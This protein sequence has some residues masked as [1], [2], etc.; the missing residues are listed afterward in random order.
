MSK[1]LLAMLRG[2][3]RS[4]RAFRSRVGLLQNLSAQPLEPKAMLSGVTV[5]T[6]PQVDS[7]GMPTGKHFVFVEG[8]SADEVITARDNGA[9]VEIDCDGVVTD[10]GIAAADV[11]TLRI[12]G[13]EGD[14]TIAID[15]GLVVERTQLYGN[16][17]DDTLVG[18]V[19]VD[20]MRGGAGADVY[21]GGDGDDRMNAGSMD[22]TPIVGGS[23]YDRLTYVPD[24]GAGGLSITSADLEYV[25]G[26]G[27]P[28]TIDLSAQTANVNVQGRGG[29]D[30]LMGG[31]AH[32]TLR[33]GD[34]DDVLMAGDGNDNLLGQAG[35]DMLDG[36]AGSDRAAYNDSDA[37]VSVNLSTLTMSGGHAT[38]DAMAGIEHLA[39]SAHD[40]VLIGDAMDNVIAGLLGDDFLMGQGGGDRHY[41]SGGND[42]VSYETSPGGVRADLA[43]NGFQD[44]DAH[45]DRAFAIENLIGSEFDDSLVGNVNANLLVGLG[46]IDD[47]DGRAGDDVLDGGDG[48]DTLVGG[49]DA[50][51]LL[52]LGGDDVLYADQA[53]FDLGL[54]D[55]GA[56]VD[57]LILVPTAA[58][59]VVV[60]VSF[61][62]VETVD[63]TTFDDIITAFGLATPITISGFGGSD[64]IEGGFGDDTLNGNS[65]DD[66]LFGGEGEDLIRGGAGDDEMGGT[67]PI[68]TPDGFVDRLIGGADF[69][70]AFDSP[71]GENIS[72][73]TEFIV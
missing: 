62:A 11:A 40:D 5:T 73:D 57:R 9:T 45:N 46:G 8:T 22:T 55:G 2:S 68:G 53:D 60:D 13:R 23:G 34:G 49:L 10:T 38:G 21:D 35:A 32:D 64:F 36:G 26:S 28:D 70:T 54:V 44:N 30:V 27:F 59:G 71:D 43:A 12:S 47:L 65:G 67:D 56:D 29:D 1:S 41:G 6:S 69:D 14:D 7:M 72:A 17:G 33:G 63:G 50:D 25:S 20:I 16:D 66:F 48:V 58:T 4:R 52:G 39:G 19:G 24:D 37:G 3:S 31:S 61:A 51:V 18:G 42:T 15:A